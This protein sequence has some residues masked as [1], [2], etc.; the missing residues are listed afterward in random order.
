MVTPFF[1]LELPNYN[2]PK[3]YMQFQWQFHPVFLFPWLTYE[4]KRWNFGLT[5]HPHPWIKSGTF[6]LPTLHPPT[7]PTTTTCHFSHLPN[8]TTLP[9]TTK[10]LKNN[11][12][13]SPHYFFKRSFMLSELK[14]K[15]IFSPAQKRS[16]TTGFGLWFANHYTADIIYL[17]SNSWSET[18]LAFYSAEA[19]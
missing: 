9:S 17:I 1:A 14:S 7:F 6:H 4:T 11:N 5:L 16:R 8:L 12:S 13:L 15:F 19:M 2:S 10:A 3:R 18:L